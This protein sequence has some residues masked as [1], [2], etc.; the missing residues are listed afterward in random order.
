[1]PGM[2]PKAK[3][4]FLII[5]H[6]ITLVYRDGSPRHGRQEEENFIYGKLTRIS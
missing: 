6:S 1:M 2:G 5:N 3:S 4:I